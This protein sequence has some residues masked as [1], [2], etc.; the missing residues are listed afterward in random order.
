MNRRS[1]LPSSRTSSA[2]SAGTDR[3]QSI[4]R[5]STRQGGP[6]KAVDLGA[7]TW[8][9]ATDR[10]DGTTMAPSILIIPLGATEQH[11]PHLPLETDTIIATAWAR[12]VAMRIPTLVAPTLPYGASGEHQGFAGTLSIGHEALQ[13]VIIELCRSARHQVRRV[14][15]L[16]GHAGNL[17]TL[18][19]VGRRLTHEG[20]QVMAMVPTWPH[21][22]T[23]SVDAHAGRTETSLMLHLRPDMIDRSK[24]GPPLGPAVRHP[25]GEN[26]PLAEI[27][28]RLRTEG[29]IGVS[30]SGILGDVTAA[31]A[32]EGRQ[33]FEELVASTVARLSA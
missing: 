24:L 3:R 22:P 25:E 6:S 4:H 19:A 10:L 21:R 16:S 17:G 12:A 23:H 28:D 2:A 13:S 20:H 11:G 15:L 33:L 32:D 30:P 18:H 5:V 31:N 27:I 1:Q 8:C 7:L 26:R 9:Q 29:V 14:V